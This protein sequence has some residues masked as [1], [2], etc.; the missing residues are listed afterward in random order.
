MKKKAAAILLAVLVLVFVPLFV[1]RDAAFG[2]SDDA[3]SAVVEEVDSSYAVS[4]THLDVYKRQACMNRGV[5]LY[6]S[7]IDRK[8]ISP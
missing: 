4:Y 7:I 5:R 6:L 1:L 3:G 2:G 8:A